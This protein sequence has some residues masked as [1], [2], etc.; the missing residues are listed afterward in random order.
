V[1]GDFEMLTQLSGMVDPFER[2]AGDYLERLVAKVWA[3]NHEL[4]RCTVTLWRHP[5]LQIDV[6]ARGAT[7][8]TRF[9]PAD[10]VLDIGNNDQTRV[11]LSIPGMR[12]AG[13]GA[14]LGR[15]ECQY[16]A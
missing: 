15:K 12:I 2:R 13:F 11:G 8:P 10:A 3:G 4:A 7:V 6:L 14:D 1:A 9:Y 16:A 5:S